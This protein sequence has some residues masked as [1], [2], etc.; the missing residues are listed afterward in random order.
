MKNIIS[1]ALL[2]LSLSVS[3]E[4]ISGRVVGISDGDTVTVLDSTNTQYKIRLS[5]IDTPE[6][7]QAFG[8]VAKKTLSDLIYDKQVNVSYTKLDRYQRVVGK[9]ELDNQDVNLVMIKAGMA[10]HYKKYQKEQPFEDRLNYLQ[11]EVAAKEQKRGLWVDPK[12]IAP[13]EFRKFKKLSISQI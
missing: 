11:A 5:G 12:P 10:W 2:L 3:A 13:W 8:N 6:K 1:F 9:V 7:K 4:T